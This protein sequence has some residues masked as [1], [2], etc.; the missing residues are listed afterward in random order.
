MP[1]LF[2]DQL[3]LWL[4][5]L[6]VTLIVTA[7]A[8]YMN[9]IK[10]GD[11][12]EISR[13]L[14]GGERLEASLKSEL[15]PELVAINKGL[16]LYYI[17]VGVYALVTGLW[18]SFTWPLPGSYNI[19]LIDPW[20]IFGIALLIIGVA[21]WSGINPRHIAIP[22]APLGIPVLVYSFVIWSFRLTRTPELS[23]LMY[24]LIG[25]STILSPA[26][27]LLGGSS[28]KAMG[29]LAIVF[30]LIAAGIAIFIGANAAFGHVA[31]WSR[32]TPWYGAVNVSS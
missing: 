16:G 5:I 10:Y 18:G 7:Y 2:V 4:M 19:V 6:G 27:L 31:G 3:D 1:I 17:F 32:W 25:L 11:L 9:I 21:L 20:S 28:R 23:G 12:R 22:L 8:I 15:R 14:G 29:W 26:I 24:F 30:L 13:S